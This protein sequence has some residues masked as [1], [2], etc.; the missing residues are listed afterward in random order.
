M[1]V[2]KAILSINSKPLIRWAYD[3]ATRFAPR[4]Y[5]SVHDEETIVHYSPLLPPEAVFVKD[6]YDGPRSALLALLSGFTSIKEETIAVIPTDSPF[7]SEKVMTYMVSKAKG[8]DLVLPMWPDGKV[9]AIHAI[10]SRPSTIP[11]LQHLW[12]E[13]TLEVK[14]IP[15]HTRT[16]FIGTEN[17]QEL[18]PPLIS[19]VDADTP[20]EFQFLRSISAG[21]Q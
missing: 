5:V 18:D 9:E 7:V 11:I 17:L 13:G 14:E 2:E 1:G 21:V 16:L 6:L 3:A 4:I 15:K 8:F 19:L 20:S 10:Y 12:S